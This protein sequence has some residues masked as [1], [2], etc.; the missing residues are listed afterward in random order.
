MEN[1]S[2]EEASKELSE[3]VSQLEE[4]TLPMS[5]AIELFERGIELIKICYSCLDNAKGKLVEIKETL[6]KLEE[7]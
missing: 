5:K 6:D 4:G 1:L 7:N 2:Y 3:I